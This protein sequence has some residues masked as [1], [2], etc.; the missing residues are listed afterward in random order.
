MN[1]ALYPQIYITNG[2]YIKNHPKKCLY[3]QYLK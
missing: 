1:R 3:A 2:M